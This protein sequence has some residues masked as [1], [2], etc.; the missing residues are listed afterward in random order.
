MVKTR[1]SEIITV[2]EIKTWDENT[3]VT[4]GAGTGAGKSYFIK[5]ILYAFAKANNK[6]IL[7]LIHRSNCVNQ[8]QREIEKDKKTDV[9]D[10]KTYQHIETK[11]K[12]KKDFD[13]SQ[14]Q[15]IV[16]DEFHYFLS[17]S[18]FNKWSDIS[19][20]AI[21]NQKITKIF[22]SA[23]GDH[24]RNYIK[25]VKKIE[26][27]DFKLESDYSSIDNLYFYNS[28]ETE[29]RFMEYVIDINGKGIMFIQSAKRAYELYTKYKDNCVFN[30]SKS[31]EEYYGYVDESEIDNILV[32]ENFEKNILI[33]TTCMDAGVNIIDTNLNNILCNVEDVQTLI[34]CIGR[35]RIQNK[36]DNFDLYIRT[37]SNCRLG[38]METQLNN[39]IKMADFL[40]EHSIKEFVEE[41]PRVYDYSNIVYDITVSDDDKCSKT[42]NELMYFKCRID[43]AMIDI[44]KTYGDYGYC[45]YVAKLFGK[46]NEYG[47]YDYHV[48]EQEDDNAKL[49][50]Q[51]ENLVGQV[52]LQTKDRKTIIDLIDVKSDGH[53]LKKIGV[54]NGALEERNICCRIVEFSTSKMIDGKKK[55]YKSAWKIMRLEDGKI[56]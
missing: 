4:I 45:K 32:N 23:T 13:F 54:L 24:T 38:G 36:H 28:E 55:N 33:T 9:I 1:V 6:K 41:F 16:S 35:K 3:V 25:N 37:I 14:Y 5:N 27:T 50:R 21:L 8:F 19:L 2:D 51:L 20:N 31:N 30:C 22:M 46:I 15:Y 12:N 56:A 18:A 40:R 48:I 39:K 11:I 44:I 47:Y 10:I 34:Q 52:F 7:M 53:Q 29:E 49:E 43:L 26:T 42:I 17:D